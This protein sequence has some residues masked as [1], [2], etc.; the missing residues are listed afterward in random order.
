MELHALAAFPVKVSYWSVYQEV[1]WDADPVSTL[2]NR[3]LLA[4]SENLTPV[5]QSIAQLLY[6]LFW[7][8]HRLANI[9]CPYNQGIF[10]NEHSGSNRV[11]I[12][13]HQLTKGHYVLKKTSVPSSLS[14]RMNI[15][16][17]IQF[18]FNVKNIQKEH[19]ICHLCMYHGIWRDIILK[20]KD[21]IIPML[22][23]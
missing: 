1:L 16:R 22:F 12:F 15:L 8:V 4:P 18:H 2:W 21:R 23:Y 3:E 5:F 20:I 17:D 11:W 9:N 13:L 6:R 7:I 10:R 19:Y 14:K